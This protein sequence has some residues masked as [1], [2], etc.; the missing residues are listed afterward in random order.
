M[1]AF[2]NFAGEALDK[3]LAQAR[4]QRY[5]K[6]SHVFEQG[7]EASSFFLLLHGRV[8]AY[9]LTAAGEQVVMR[10]VGPGEFFGIAPAMTLRAYPA[11]AVAVVDSVALVWPAAVWATMAEENPALS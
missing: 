7:A 5:A 6:N 2:K 10:F 11:N 9:K 1:P 3:V 4:S 8:R